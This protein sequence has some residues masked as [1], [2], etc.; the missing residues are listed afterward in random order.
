[1][2]ELDNSSKKILMQTLES[3]E[4]YLKLLGVF[5]ND[6]ETIN[7][8]DKVMDLIFSSYD[9]FNDLHNALNESLKVITSVSTLRELENLSSKLK[10]ARTSNHYQIAMKA[11]PKLHGA[12]KNADVRSKAMAFI[13]QALLADPTLK[14]NKLAKL[15]NKVSNENRQEFGRPIPVSTA[16]DYAREVKK[17]LEGS[18]D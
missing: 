2:D 15:V 16:K 8:K 18:S 5:L 13:K 6:K 4:E 10:L 17:Q 11:I 3:S 14:I 12:K 1:M 7:S 9:A